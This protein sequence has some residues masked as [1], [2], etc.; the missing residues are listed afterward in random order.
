MIAGVEKTMLHSRPGSK[1]AAEAARVRQ[2]LLA[3]LE[4]VACALQE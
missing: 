4:S 3:E 2:V 1:K